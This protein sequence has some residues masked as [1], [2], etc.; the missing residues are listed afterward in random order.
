[1]ATAKTI[2]QQ[3][4]EAIQLIF[5][6]A[7]IKKIDKDNLLDIHIPEINEKKGTHLYFNTA[8]D[9]IK[10]GFYCR[11]E[12]FI[13]DVIEREFES[14]EADSHGLRIKGNPI[15]TSV[16][17]AISATLN[18]LNGITNDRVLN[19]KTQESNSND[20]V[21][22][23]DDPSIAAFVENFGNDD[24]SGFLENYL[25]SDKI[26]VLTISRNDLESATVNNVDYSDN[27]E[28]LGGVELNDWKA[29][30]K[31]IGKSESDWAKNEFTAEN[32]S[33][34]VLLYSEGKYVYAFSNPNDIELEGDYA[35]DLDENNDNYF[36]NNEDDNIN[37]DNVSFKIDKDS[38]PQIL[39][40]I[41]VYKKLKHFEI[42]YYTK[43]YSDL[44]YS[45]VYKVNNS[46]IQVNR[47][48]WYNDSYWTGKIERNE[49]IEGL[50]KYYN[51][52]IDGTELIDEYFDRGIVE[53]DFNRA[54]NFNN[55]VD[56]QIT[57]I[58]DLKDIP[59]D[60]Q[61]DD[62]N[63]D[64]WELSNFSIPEEEDLYDDN[65][66]SV[67]CYEIEINDKTYELVVDEL[68]EEEIQKVYN[69]SEFDIDDLDLLSNASYRIE[70]EK[71][72]PG[73]LYMPNK[74]IEEG[75][76]E[77][78]NPF[79]FTSLVHISDDELSGFL[80]VDAQGF[81]SDCYTENEIKFIF[82][83]DGLININI[84]EE[85]A[86]SIKIELISTKATLI[87]TEPYSKNLKVLLS[88]YNTIW[89]DVIFRFA[90]EK[91]Y[92]WDIIQN[93]MGV[94]I[95]TFDSQDEYISWISEVGK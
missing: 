56:F 92:D 79:F 39:E 11:D 95:L 54:G 42:S 48:N 69:F 80:F 44:N 4:A 10:I 73:L 18:F 89:K 70:N 8:K 5:K 40:D 50:K 62:G 66:G 78:Q 68:K 52:E 90:D 76:E 72:L 75:F 30:S 84:L 85:D 65:V 49:L 43:E 88:I 27:V 64:V 74:L 21:I 14:I 38:I 60:L 23:E 33:G 24:L 46:N 59:E 3:L 77:T 71:V 20:S 58:D 91:D 63:L 82:S 22:V 31:L 81:H 37:E 19:S 94:T 26:I 61:D 32:P 47:V 83:W 16:M 28:Y 53:Y 25:E 67:Y 9:Q 51:G 12:N 34:I 15:F 13:N 93:E 2:Q 55:G 57:D 36:E 1:M 7:S 87:I 86:S 6:D 17:T 41:N 45:L 35:N 29:L